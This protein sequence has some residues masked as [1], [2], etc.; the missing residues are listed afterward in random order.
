[1]LMIRGKQSIRGWRGSDSPRYES[2]DSRDK[3]SPPHGLI[4]RSAIQK[5]FARQERIALVPQNLYEF[6]AVATRSAGP[7]P[8][9]ENGLGHGVEQA[10]QWLIFFQRR[11]TLLPD[12]EDLPARR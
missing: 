11:F 8:T 5:L 2:A 3:C 12:R 1:M 6:W 10:S 4:A 9:G 7:R